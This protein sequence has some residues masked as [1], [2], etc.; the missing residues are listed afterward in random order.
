MQYPQKPT[1]LQLLPYKLEHKLPKRQKI[2]FTMTCTLP[3]AS[4]INKVKNNGILTTY[5][6]YCLV[7]YSTIFVLIF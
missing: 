2:H 7:G 4:L 5:P 6:I 3:K 1:I